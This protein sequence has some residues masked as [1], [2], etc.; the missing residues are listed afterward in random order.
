MNAVVLTGGSAYGLAAADGVMAALEQDGIGFPVGPE[1]G[2]VVPIVPAAVIFD[3]GRGGTFGHRP[4][5]E[6]GAR[7][8]RRLRRAPR[9][10]VRRWR[11]RRGVRRAQGRLRLRRT[12]ARRRYVGG[13]GRGGQ[14]HRLAGRP[15]HRPAVGRPRAA[16]ADPAEAER[17]ALAAA[18]G[19][20]PPSLATT[21]GVL[22]TDATLTKAQASRLATIG[23][24]GMARA[25]AP[26]HSMMDGDTV[27]ALASGRRPAPTTHAAL[28]GFQPA[29][30]RGRRC[31]HR[32]LPRC[33]ARR[34]GPGTVA[35]LPRA[36]AVSRA[37]LRNRLGPPGRFLHCG[38]AERPRGDEDA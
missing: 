29:A 35:G 38:A 25:I 36:G 30:G 3:L 10:R 24:D 32:R 8:R 21:I 6:F 22:L 26:V 18:Y 15:D 7:A 12:P 17:R 13:R 28:V 4:T 31:V 37:G 23:H 27:F 20:R 19:Q 1:P 34:R 11:D 33:A 2:Q 16:A 14:C 9:V 5:A